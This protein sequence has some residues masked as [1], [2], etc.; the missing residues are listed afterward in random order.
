MKSRHREAVEIAYMVVMQMGEDDILDRVSVDAE[1]TER[2]HRAAQE[3][4]LA[5][6]RCLRVEASVDD[7]GAAFTPRHP[8]EIVHRHRTIVRVAADEMLAPPRLAGGIAD[9]KELVFRFGHGVPRPA[10]PSGLSWLGGTMA[11]LSL[12]SST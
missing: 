5:F 1:R 6:V 7:K 3:G 10:Q 12:I 9:G 8:N 4:A 11:L 2:L